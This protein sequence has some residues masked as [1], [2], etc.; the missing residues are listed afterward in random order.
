[1]CLTLP[2]YYL[3][4]IPERAL[5]DLGSSNTKVDNEKEFINKAKVFIN[6]LDQSLSETKF[7]KEYDYNVLELYRLVRESLDEKHPYYFLT[8]KTVDLYEKIAKVHN[9]SGKSEID[10]LMIE[11]AAKDAELL[12]LNNEMNREKIDHLS[13]VN[14]LNNEIR[15]L[16]NDLK[17]YQY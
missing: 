13:E 17:S 12:R 6:E 1:M 14:K 11:I 5:S 9:E 3:F 7:G 15:D 10:K 2:L 4:K 8:H 16:K